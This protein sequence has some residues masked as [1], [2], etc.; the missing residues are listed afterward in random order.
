LAAPFAAPFGQRRLIGEGLADQAPFLFTGRRTARGEDM[1]LAKTSLAALGA[2]ACLIGGLAPA[3]AELPLSAIIAQGKAIIDLRGRFETIEDASKT[4]DANAET[5]RAR[6]GYDTGYWN[7]FQFGFEFDQIWSVGGATYNSTRNG[8]TL[9]PTVLDPAMTALDRLTLTYASDFDTK[10]TIG[11][12]RLLIGNQR[13]VGNAAWRQHEQTY[14]SISAANNSVSDLTLTYAWLYRIN[15][16]GGP[17]IPAPS[18]TPAAATA[19]ANYLKSDS[20]VMDAVYIG[21][22][23]LR[24]EA[25]SFLLDLK[26]PGYA[27]LPAQQTAVARLSTATYG[28][29]A[30]YNFV[31][32]GDVAAK[33]TGEYAHQTNNANN[34]LSFGLDYWLGEASA[35]YAGFTAL[36]GYEV[37]GGNGVIGFA[38][39]LAT[40]HIFNGWADMFLTTPVNGLKDFYLKGVYTVPADFLEMKSLTGTVYYHNYTTDRLGAGIGS[41]WDAQ[42]ELAVDNNFSLLAKFADYQG[43]NVALGGFPDKRIVWLQTAYRY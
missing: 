37:L 10:F 12:Q 6:L 33:L 30:D 23:G 8:K 31:F 1:K 43:S 38:T 42:A 13:F 16:I 17:A 19:Q 7:N 5:F 28:G 39:P 9:Y 24:L 11:R 20:H 26:P 27:T 36:A 15:R 40:L 22:D 41:E 3:H 18:N 35:S 14:D 34:P 29:R 2:S 21:V 25:Y 32:P 4:V